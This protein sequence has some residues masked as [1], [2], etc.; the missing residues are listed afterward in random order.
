MKAAEH[1]PKKTAPRCRI[2][3]QEDHATRRSATQ[4]GATQR[5]AAQR[6]AAQRGAAQRG[7][8]QRSAGSSCLAP[9]QHQPGTMYS[10]EE[11]GEAHI[12]LA[13]AA[14]LVGEAD[15]GPGHG[16]EDEAAQDA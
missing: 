3:R 12:L 16:G 10:L 1:R 8:A 2:R 7:A 15:G 6:G 11:L 4:R 13:G 14:K 5:G 9:R